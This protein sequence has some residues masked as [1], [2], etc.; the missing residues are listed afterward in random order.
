MDRTNGQVL[1]A[2]PFGYITSSKGVD[3]ASGK[4]IENEEK[5]PE[6][7]KVVREICPAAPGAKDWQPS[8]F[9]PRTGLVISRTR[10][11]ARMLK[12]LRRITSR[13]GPTLG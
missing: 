2:N 6:V 8:A 12:G 13:A 1:S 3:L 5:K 11:F 10:T 9:S 4:L 7:G